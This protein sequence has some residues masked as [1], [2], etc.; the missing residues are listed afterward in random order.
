MNGL[1]LVL[2]MAYRSTV[3]EPIVHNLA[4]FSL[5]VCS[6]VLVCLVSLVF[7]FLNSTRT[8]LEVGRYDD[9]YFSWRRDRESWEQTGA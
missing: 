3:S 2:I 9:Y 6:S 1:L 8:R 7:T 4:P 5:E